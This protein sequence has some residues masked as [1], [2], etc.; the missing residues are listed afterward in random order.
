MRPHGGLFV[1]AAALQGRTAAQLGGWQDNQINTTICYWKQPR[2]ALIRDTVY[3]DGGELWW[4]PGLASGSLGPPTNQGNFQGTIL[5]FNLSTPMTETTNTTALLLNHPLQKAHGVSASPNALDGGM[6]ANDAEFFLYG[7]A[8]LRND[9]LY[10][11]PASDA[12][13]A[14]QAFKYGVEKPLMPE[15]FRDARLDQGVTRYL[16]YGAAASAPS[17]NKAW[18]FSGLSSPSRGPIL[19]N[20]SL[21]GSTRAM[22]VSNTLVTLDM[23]V[24]LGEKWS[25]DTL[26]STVKG[27][28]NAEVVWVPVGKQGILVV[29]GGVTYPEWAS[30]IH[31][32]DD[33]AASTRESPA[34]M[35][36]I[37]IYDVATGRWY[38]Q[39][40]TGGPASRARGCAVVAPA[41]DRSSFNIYYYGGFDGIHPQSPFHDD[42]WVLSLPSFTWTLINR[43]TELHARA[44]H[45]CFLPYP[46]QMMVF[47]G[48]AAEAGD[49]PSCLDGGPI[50]VFNIT[51]GEWIK[52]YDPATYGPYGVHENV[53]AV[54]GGDA[55]GGATATA[56]APSAWAAPELG[57]V[58]A[59]RYDSSKI[60]TY[61]PYQT[62]VTSGRAE[63][64]AGQASNSKRV[65]IPAVVVPIVVLAGM[66]VVV[67]GY[68]LRRHR[69]R[70]SSSQDSD[71]AAMR[72][73]SWVRG[74]ATGKSLTM[75]SSGAVSP[76]PE[77][78]SA[79]PMSP[80]SLS[81]H[82]EMADT[83]VAEL[84]DTSPPVE[85]HDT[86]LTPLE[87]IQK[88]TGFRPNRLQSPS[89]PSHSSLSCPGDNN[90]FVSQSSGAAHVDSPL[91]GCSPLLDLKPTTDP[92]RSG[93]LPSMTEEPPQGSASRYDEGQSSTVPVKKSVFRENVGDDG[94][95]VEV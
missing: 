12:V 35:R 41:A 71:E 8:L 44:G 57:R 84:A 33:E 95:D 45:R 93:A 69:S 79:S 53:R 65:I 2:A 55:S 80:V 48:Y 9:V 77:M 16:A 39:P 92:R 13:L 51:S 61:W 30:D 86:G 40:T 83:Q 34:F 20:P 73:R 60:K 58:F 66:A 49:L 38:Q 3:L 23:S 31:K 25:N 46:D 94:R 17:E 75:T 4:S 27:R 89:D 14:Y 64:P 15:G 88:H 76:E 37:D 70:V 10:Q 56:P 54:I 68:R 90:S 21:N 36:N 82:H 29:L 19:S 87:V 7:G 26:P 81:T 42:V 62:S 1:V 6:L 47:G 43:G 50:V 24:Q 32:S 85:L 67:W 78:M 22:N 5:T 11:Q 52:S 74:Q 63:I 72:I 28:S 59:D 18:Y 91:L